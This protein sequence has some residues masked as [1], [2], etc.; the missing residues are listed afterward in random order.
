[1]R[2]KSG[3]QYF[4][5]AVSDLALSC[6]LYVSVSKILGRVSTVDSREGV[7]FI[8]LVRVIQRETH[9]D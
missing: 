5:V 9:M 1:M 7:N 4:M 6:M 2:I 3:L 8:W